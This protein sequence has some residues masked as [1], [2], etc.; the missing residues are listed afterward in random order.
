MLIKILFEF[1][2]FVK[3]QNV[4]KSRIQLQTRGG[5]ITGCIFLFTDGP[6]NEGGGGGGGGYKRKLT[7]YRRETKN[8]IT[9]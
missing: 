4:V 8:N 3:L 6:T 7:A 1:D 9:E 5:L 2:L